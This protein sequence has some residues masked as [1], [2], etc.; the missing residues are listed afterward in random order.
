MDIL[1]DKII[2]FVNDYQIIDYL[3]LD[4]TNNK[5]KEFVKD[6]NNKAHK[7]VIRA[8]TQTAG[9]GRHKREWISPSGN[10]YISIILDLADKKNKFSELSFVTSIALYNTLKKYLPHNITI[11]Y[12][13]P[14]DVLVDSKKIAGILLENHSDYPNNIIIGIGLNI[15]S[16]PKFAANILYQTTCINEL[17]KADID[18]EELTLNLLVEFERIL[19]KW[20]KDSFAVIKEL[21]LD[22]ALNLGKELKIN[23]VNEEYKGIFLGLDDSGSLILQEKA[24]NIRYIKS[25]DVYL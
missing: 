12:K 19:A 17:I 11:G 7:V 2:S 15:Q 18:K 9:R 20:H 5:A 23:L 6:K 24:G 21:W 3:Q 16:S 4:S 22:N 1:D 25:G 10:L 8:Q 14:N 13:W